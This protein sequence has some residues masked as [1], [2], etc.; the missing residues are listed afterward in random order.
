[1]DKVVLEDGKYLFALSEDGRLYCERYSEP[2][3]SFLGDKAVHALFQEVLTLRASLAEPRFTDEELSL[4]WNEAYGAIANGTD[5]AL[6]AAVEA[7]ATAIKRWR[8]AQKT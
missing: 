4:V 8:S 5:V 3:R 7:K 1:M 2:W 6:F